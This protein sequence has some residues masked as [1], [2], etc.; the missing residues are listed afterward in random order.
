LGIAQQRSDSK[1]G[2]TYND[3]AP[4]SKAFTHRLRHSAF[5]AQLTGLYSVGQEIRRYKEILLFCLVLSYFD[6][7]GVFRACSKPC[8]LLRLYSVGEK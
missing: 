7:D 1:H 6:A 3:S 8:R 5:T 2:V 4:S